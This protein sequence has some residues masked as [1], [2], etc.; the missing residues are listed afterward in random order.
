MAMNPAQRKD[1][2]VDYK[3]FTYWS[4][5]FSVLMIPDQS[6]IEFML[7]SDHK[8]LPCDIPYGNSRCFDTVCLL[9]VLH[10]VSPYRFMYILP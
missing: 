5:L 6:F 3:M 7:R 1:D 10:S 8:D 9:C 4:P 2:H